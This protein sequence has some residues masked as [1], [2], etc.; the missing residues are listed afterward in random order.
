MNIFD[1]PKHQE[2]Q[3]LRQTIVELEKGHDRNAVIHTKDNLYTIL[4]ERIVWMKD[5]GLD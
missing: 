3:E 1:F 5:N 2:I 4:Q